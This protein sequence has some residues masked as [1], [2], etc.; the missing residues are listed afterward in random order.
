M[1]LPSRFCFRYRLGNCFF[2]L[3]YSIKLRCFKSNL[4]E[5][6]LSLDVLVT[7]LID[8][9][10]SS[11]FLF[12][13]VVG[14]ILACSLVWSNDFT[15]ANVI[16]IEILLLLDQHQI[17]QCLLPLFQLIALLV[18]LLLYLLMILLGP[19]FTRSFRIINIFLSDIFLQGDRAK[20]LMTLL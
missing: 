14:T 5:I 11:T 6:L 12:S 8:N 15:L 9:S 1:R 13:V 10:S 4:F 3:N 17:I 2:S 16:E 7:L 19:I 20:K 18:N